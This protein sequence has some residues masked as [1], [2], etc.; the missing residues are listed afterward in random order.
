VRR[1]HLEA[2]REVGL[3]NIALL[4]E[5]LDAP[6][7]LRVK[8]R[9]ASSSGTTSSGQFPTSGRG[10]G[11]RTNS[12]KTPTESAAIRFPQTAPTLAV[13]KCAAS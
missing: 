3:I 12:R 10:I 7:A 1:F 11:V 4:D 8:S 5:L 2:M 6:N 13:P 9:R